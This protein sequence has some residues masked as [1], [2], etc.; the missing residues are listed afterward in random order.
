MPPANATQTIAAPLRFYGRDVPLKGDL[1]AEQFLRELEGR[2]AGQE[3]TTNATKLAF[4]A[5]CMHGDAFAFYQGLAGHEEYESTFSSFK[6]LFRHYYNLPGASIDTFDTNKLHNQRIDES[7]HHYLNRV[8]LYVTSSFP[9][10][11][12]AQFFEDTQTSFD[13]GVA[14]N[15]P[16]DINNAS[17]RALKTVAI[18]VMTTNL[19]KHYQTFWLRYIWTQGLMRPYKEIAALQDNKLTLSQ[20]VNKVTKAGGN[21]IQLSRFDSHTEAMKAYNKRKG[22]KNN[23][24]DPSN[25]NGLGMISNKVCEII[26]ADGFEEEVDAVQSKSNT[27]LTCSYCHKP[28]HVEKQCFK[29]ARDA[30]NRR[31]NG[32]HNAQNSSNGSGKNSGTSVNSAQ[33]GIHSTLASLQTQ[34]NALTAKEKKRDET[35]AVSARP[36]PNPDF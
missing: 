32:S 33:S 5:Q 20:I 34:I 28:N 25:T 31:S 7:P 15:F 17:K 27:G 26:D 4:T 35:H 24:V 29:K 9:A 19:E 10:N 21:T 23:G 36:N 6:K 18:S 16:A 8:R 22:L 30:K 11:H 13:A 14:E 1:S 2:I 12:F 3:L